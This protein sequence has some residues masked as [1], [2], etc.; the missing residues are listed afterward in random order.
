M[1]DQ[2]SVIPEQLAQQ[3]E[4]QRQFQAVQPQFLPEL[5]QVLAWPDPQGDAGVCIVIQNPAGQS[6]HFWPHS[7]ALEMVSHIK[8]T[9]TGS[10]LVEVNNKLI[11]PQG[12]QV[13]RPS[14]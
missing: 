1:T 13:P 3:A 9:A 12:V 5:V 10:G 14:E 11:V 2:P 7:M 6:V 4:Q 8:K